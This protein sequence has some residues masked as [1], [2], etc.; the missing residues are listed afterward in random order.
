[1]KYIISIFII[2][3]VVLMT[4]CNHDVFTDDSFPY[5]NAVMLNPNLTVDTAELHFGVKNLQAVEFFNNGRATKVYD[6]EGNLL[7]ESSGDEFLELPFGGY[8]LVQ[9]Q[10]ID[11]IDMKVGWSTQGT[12][13]V[14]LSDF[15]MIQTVSDFLLRLS[16]KDKQYDIPVFFESLE[17]FEFVSLEYDKESFVR[18]PD[19]E[20]GN[21]KTV[22]NNNTETATTQRL[23]PYNGTYRYVF[24]SFPFNIFNLIQNVSPEPLYVEIPRMENDSLI[25]EGEK[26]PFEY[27]QNLQPLVTTDTYETIT[28]PP[29][30]AITCYVTYIRDQFVITA[31][32]TLK[33]LQSG[34]L[35]KRTA[36]IS[37]SNPQNYILRIESTPL[38]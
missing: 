6:A 31:E 15:I 21:Q 14:I 13:K 24:M 3:T 11:V 23:Y 4:S 36:E 30:T 19:W 22:I 8:I 20:F 18:M 7:K 2:F 16:Y 9:E 12:I 34:K 28:I 38:K 33:N 35:L 1:M 32:L 10:D 27:S 5:E 37:V 29:Y 26:V 25:F 17:K